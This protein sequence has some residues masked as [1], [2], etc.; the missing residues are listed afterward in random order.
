VSSSEPYSS[1]PTAD[2]IVGVA[3]SGHYVSEMFRNG[4][5]RRSTYH[6]GSICIHQPVESV[7]YRFPRPEPNHANF[8]TAMLYLP[9][10]QMSAAVDHFRRAGQR[11]FGLSANVGRDPAITQMTSALLRATLDK[12]D[13]LYAETAAAW[14]AVYL[15]SRYGS[16]AGM[17]DRR[18]GGTLSDARLARVIEFMS[19]HFDKPLTL[20]QLAS[21]ACVSRFHFARLF[22]RKVGQSPF[23]FLSGIR[24]EAARRMLITSDLSSAEIGAACGYRAPSHFSAAFSARYGLSPTAF[25]MTRGRG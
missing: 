16:V 13:D 4:Q 9:Q 14:L 20:D 11:V 21:E 19:V 23:R 12:V 18:T 22:R 7:R 5:W 1:I 2:Q 24:L 3:L 10:M 15:V 25:R 8:T 17:D 6:P